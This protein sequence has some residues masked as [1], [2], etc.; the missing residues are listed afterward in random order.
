MGV[1]KTLWSKLKQ[2]ILA[3]KPGR[4]TLG[5]PFTPREPEEGFRGLPR[6]DVNRC[7]GCGGC[8]EVC[9]ARCIRVVDTDQTTRVL[10]FLH[11]R[12]T[13]CGRCAEVC[14]VNA[15][16]M[17]KEF[18]LSTDDPHED[19]VGEYHI[20]M[21]PCERCGRCFEAPSALDRLKRTGMRCD[22]IDAKCA[23]ACPAG[24]EAD[25][26]ETKS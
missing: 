7:I 24:V 6:V 16:E 1:L 15:I 19:L 9:P 11:E 2:A 23:I 18:E 8:A 26:E 3:L 14:P 25:S 12:C 10:C 17:T 4:V 22:E 13:F 20:W 21:G 5:Y